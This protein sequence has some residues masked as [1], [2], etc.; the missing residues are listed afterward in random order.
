MAEITVLFVYAGLD[1]EI[2]HGTK[3]MRD[4]RF[5]NAIPQIRV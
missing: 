2:G 5:G 1:G 4:E 3:E